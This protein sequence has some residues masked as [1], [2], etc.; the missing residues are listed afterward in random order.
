MRNGQAKERVQEWLEDEMQRRAE[1]FAEE[2]C[3]IWSETGKGVKKA[4]AAN[5]RW[6]G[7]DAARGHLG[8]A[9]AIR[10]RSARIV[11]S[12]EGEHA[13]VGAGHWVHIDPRERCHIAQAP[14][15]P[16]DAI[17]T[18]PGA[19]V[20][21]RREARTWLGQVHTRRYLA[22]REHLD[23]EEAERE[24]LTLAQWVQGKAQGD[25]I[26]PGERA[27]EWMGREKDMLGWVEVGALARA[28]ATGERAAEIGALERIIP[29]AA[30]ATTTIT[31][32]DGSELTL[33]AKGAVVGTSARGRG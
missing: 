24:G 16:E 4:L 26:L 17:A 9:D 14:P 22:W 19:E 23:V 28:L 32:V 31:L 27:G 10:A 15:G 25:K 11:V 12:K 29:K 30:R 33:N 5:R 7:R 8:C 18:H 20:R 6:Q 13:E 21:S 3:R 2:W 1:T